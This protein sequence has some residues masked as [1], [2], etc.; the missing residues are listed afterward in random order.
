MKWVLNLP[1]MNRSKLLLK[2]YSYIKKLS[3][4]ST[5][6]PS[7]FTKFLW[8]TWLITS[9]SLKNWST[10]CFV[11]RNSLFAATSFPPGRTACMWNNYNLWVTETLL[12][13]KTQHPCTQK[14]KGSTYIPCTQYH[15]CL[16]LSCSLHWMNMSLSLNPYNCNSDLIWKFLQVVQSHTSLQLLKFFKQLEPIKKK[17]NQ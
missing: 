1:Y 8:R 5:L 17:Q 11:F 14:K 13:C 2:W 15:C 7:N 10:H 16:G 9:T 4:P 3:G 12:S 6:H